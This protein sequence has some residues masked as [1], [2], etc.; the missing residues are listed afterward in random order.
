MSPDVP[1]H[2]R[3]VRGQIVGSLWPDYRQPLA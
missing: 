1:G 3:S 2:D